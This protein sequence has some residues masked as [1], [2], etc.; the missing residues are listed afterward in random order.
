MLHDIGKVGI[1]DEIMLKNGKLT[2][3]E[4]RIMTKHTVLGADIYKEIDTSLDEMVRT[5]ALYH[6]EKWNGT[7]YRGEE[8][9]PLSGEAIPWPARVTAIADVFDALTSKRAYKDAWSFEESVKTIQ[10]D[11]GTH[12]DPEMVKAFV[13]I[14]DTIRAIQEKY[15][16]M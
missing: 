15:S 7:G 5:V 11:A 8:G 1:P 2:E 3:E 10:K 6:H 14:L 16:E 13:E 12:F 4:F 9:P